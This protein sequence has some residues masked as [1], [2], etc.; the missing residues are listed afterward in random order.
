MKW[1]L[2]CESFSAP[3][4]YFC[5]LKCQTVGELLKFQHY[6]FKLPRDANA[7][8]LFSGAQKK[9]GLGNMGGGGEFGKITH[10][11]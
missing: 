6:K 2:T 8:A 11:S 10:A 9:W 3:S 4:I 1:F 7:L 5:G